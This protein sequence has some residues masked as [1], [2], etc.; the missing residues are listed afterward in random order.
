MPQLRMSGATPPLPHKISWFMQIY[1]VSHK[2]R[3]L[4]LDLIPELM[5]SKKRHIHMG[6]IG[7]GSGVM[8]F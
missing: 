4:I 6:P 7:N 8:S 5:L 2:L 1:R 3:S